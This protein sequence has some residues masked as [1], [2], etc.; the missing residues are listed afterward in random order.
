[1]ENSL[2]LIIEDEP[3]IVEILES[4]FTREGFRTI[5]ARDGAIGLA[6]HQR[7]KPDLVVLDV[8]LPGQDGYEV[9]AAI[10]R[11]GDTPVI[12]VTALADDLDKLQALRIGADD[13]VVKPFN[14]LEVVARAKAVLRRAIGSNQR[15]AIR[16][17]PLGVDL[18]AHEAWI[19]GLG[20]RTALTLTRTE[21]RLL[22]FMAASPNRVFDRAEMID[23]CL[24]EGEALER[25]VDTHM[26][27][28]R[29]KLSQAGAAE[30]L[31]G[32]RGVGYKLTDGHG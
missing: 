26:S 18:S 16:V 17:G 3:E 24:P 21:F 1:M 29:R 4:Y 31:T 7:L 22:A 19:E 32:V 13:Y 8:K 23:A 5:S 2:V 10:R 28:L 20:S 30:L 27:N 12:M 9:L 11:R 15:T 14:P 6:H 25:T